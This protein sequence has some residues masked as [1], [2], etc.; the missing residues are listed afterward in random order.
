MTRFLKFVIPNKHWRGLSKS[1]S[2]SMEYSASPDLED[3]SHSKKPKQPEY[4]KLFMDEIQYLVNTDPLAEITTS[5]GDMKNMGFKNFAPGSLVKMAWLYKNTRLVYWNIV[6]HLT[7]RKNLT[8][9]TAEFCTL[10]FMGIMY[11]DIPRLQP[12]LEHFENHLLRFDTMAWHSKLQL[13]L[14]LSKIGVFP[15]DCIKKVFS[16]TRALV[17]SGEIFV[18]LQDPNHAGIYLYFLNE[19]V[20]KFATV[21]VMEA[22]LDPSVLAKFHDFACF[23]ADIKYKFKL[24]PYANRVI[25]SPV[26]FP[27]RQL[28]C[29]FLKN[30]YAN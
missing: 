3:S 13:V 2:S 24:A 30:L 7:E 26:N 23:E 19:F 18:R 22:L 11:D 4:Y 8:L 6:E 27:V 10:G 15:A 20:S 5:I 12:I 25:S 1:F 21:E 9:E 17:A 28:L 16:E 29:S 14:A